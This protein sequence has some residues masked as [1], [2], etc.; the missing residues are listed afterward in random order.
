M[1]FNKY[2]VMVILAALRDYRER[3]RGY[4]YDSVYLK[5]DAKGKADLDN[6]ARE[7][8]N[9]IRRIQHKMLFDKE[10]ED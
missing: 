10:G 4:Q 1:D 7:T 2:E 9:M 6:Q 3:L 5:A 8:E